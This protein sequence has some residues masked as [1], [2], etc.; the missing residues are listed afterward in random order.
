MGP[1]TKN[2]D[3]RVYYLTDELVCELRL[4]GPRRIRYGRGPF[5]VFG[6]ANVAGPQKPWKWTC[7][8]AGIRYLTPHEAG[9]MAPGRRP[10]AP[11]R[12]SC[13]GSQA[14]GLEGPDG[15]AAP[16]R[17]R[18]GTRQGGERIFGTEKTPFNGT[19]VTHGKREVG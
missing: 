19:P 18:Q 3:P 9:D 4:L 16:V 12:R 2:G 5:R 14:R 10:R 11:G 13:Y 6:W 15:V 8:R 1:P 7:K 17:P